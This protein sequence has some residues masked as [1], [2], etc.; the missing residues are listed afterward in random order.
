MKQK[1]ETSEITQDL[2]V[3]AEELFVYG[4][5]QTQK[6]SE[7]L[8][9]PKELIELWRREL[10]WD[11]KQQKFV[12][13]LD[14]EI[15]EKTKKKIA[16]WVSEIDE[17]LAGVMGKVMKD[18]EEQKLKITSAE[19]GLNIILKAVGERLKILQMLTVAL[20]SSQIMDL[21]LTNL[22]LR[23][24]DVK[25]SEKLQKWSEVQ[26]ILNEIETMK[27]LN[28]SLPEEEDNAK[29]SKD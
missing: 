19:Q 24:V 1:T 14:R 10:N 26:K 29:N 18:L 17:Y 11:R 12:R 8:S 15:Q 9:V 28:S 13:Q 7:L 21:N 25:E 20:Q 2:I 5:C 3:K 16:V 4:F 23:E 27:G 22:A 6:I